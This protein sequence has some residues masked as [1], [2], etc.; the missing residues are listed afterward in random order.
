[1]FVTL[2][3]EDYI[4]TRNVLK[5]R[6]I[7]NF[8]VAFRQDDL[9]IYYKDVQFSRFAVNINEAVIDVE[10]VN[11]QIFTVS[12]TQIKIYIM[13]DVFTDYADKITFVNPDLIYSLDLPQQTNIAHIKCIND[14]IYIS[15]QYALLHFSLNSL[16][17]TPYK[18]DNFCQFSSNSTLVSIQGAIIIPPKTH[19]VNYVPFQPGQI[20]DFTEKSIIFGR[21]QL[22]VLANSKTHNI[23]YKSLLNIECEFIFALKSVFLDNDQQQES[24]ILIIYDSIYKAFIS[25]INSLNGSSFTQFNINILSDNITGYDNSLSWIINKNDK[26][27]IFSCLILSQPEQKQNEK[28]I[29]DLIIQPKTFKF[30]FSQEI[31]ENPENLIQ[32]SLKQESLINPNHPKITAKKQ[33]LFKLKEKAK[34]TDQ[35]IMYHA[36]KP[37][38]KLEMP[39]SEKHK[40]GQKQSNVP[41]KSQTTVQNQ[42]DVSYF[43]TLSQTNKFA[44]ESTQFTQIQLSDTHVAALTNQRKTIF[45]AKNLS[46]KYDVSFS[47]NFTNFSLHK[48]GKMVA[49]SGS[50]CTH[51]YNINNSQ[52]KLGQKIESNCVQNSAFLSFL[53]PQHDEFSLLARSCLGCLEF[54]Y[55][56]Q[57]YNILLKKVNFPLQISCGAAFTKMRS[58]HVL[59]GFTGYDFDRQDNIWFNIYD[60]I[61]EKSVF[62]IKNN[63]SAFKKSINSIFLPDFDL[64]NTN[65]FGVES[66]S[67][68]VIYDFRQE[69]SV[70]SFEGRNACFVTSNL[71]VS[72]DSIFD[73]RAGKH[74][75][76]TCNMNCGVG[77]GIGCFIGGDSEISYYKVE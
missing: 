36:P 37:L 61:S 76:I 30:Q 46:P 41:P 31:A 66:G 14:Q 1:M 5:L 34:K 51:I 28:R 32:I 62:S 77:T 11:H 17:L 74:R 53:W 49:F 25:P 26:Q 70:C 69:N 60:I 22:S 9:Q 3:E 42:A 54:F 50:Q 7:S 68:V 12:A 27:Q 58:P 55:I 48:G 71:I 57:Q 19:S 18:Q 23:S 8:I 72:K 24:L 2:F 59:M 10:I 45:F 56:N 29:Y 64:S 16:E 33:S 63:N 44:L 15:V 40:L 4:T 35:K 75:K 73:I 21:S 47:E 38:I 13:P 65:L 67:Q 52:P 20:I 6:Q 43:S 39:W